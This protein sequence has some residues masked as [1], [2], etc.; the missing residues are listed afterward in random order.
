MGYILLSPEYIKSESGYNWH[1]FEAE[2]IE[3]NNRELT[4][5]ELLRVTKLSENYYNY[6]SYLQLFIKEIKNSITIERNNIIG[7]IKFELNKKSECGTRDRNKD[8]IENK[9]FESFDI[10]YDL[11]KGCI[12]Y[13]FS[14]DDIY[15]TDRNRTFFYSD[16]EDVIR[17]LACTLGRDVCGACMSKL[18]GDD[19]GNNEED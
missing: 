17:I 3:N 16:N 1:L 6:H 11:S 4:L 18:Y 7:K 15:Y 13:D 14:V 12:Q 8:K 10:K 19:N 2:L 9:N 5:R